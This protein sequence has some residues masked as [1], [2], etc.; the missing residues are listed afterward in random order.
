MVR[1]YIDKSVKDGL[2]ETVGNKSGYL[3][4]SYDVP[5]FE[6]CIG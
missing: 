5:L 6:F 1:L 4:S 2:L 3:V